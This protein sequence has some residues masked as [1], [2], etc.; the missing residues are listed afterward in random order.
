[1]PYVEGESL[2]ERLARERQLPVAEAVRLAREVAGA[3]QYAHARGVV[4]RDVK[5]ENILL[6]GAPGAEGGTRS[7]P[8]S[9][10]PWRSPRRQARA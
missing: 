2:R 10:S 6:Q 7:S 1:M 3:L 8:T 4:H 9:A 5:P